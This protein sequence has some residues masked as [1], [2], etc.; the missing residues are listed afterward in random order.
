MGLLSGNSCNIITIL[1]LGVSCGSINA[2]TPVS[3]NGLIA[4]YV[5][6]GTPPYNIL[7]NN[8]LKDSPITNLLPGDYTVTVTDYYGDFSATTTCTVGYDSFYLEKF[9]NCQNISEYAYYLADLTNLFDNGKIYK[10]TTQNGCWTSSG[11]TLFTGQTYINQFA[12]TNFPPYTGCSE[13]LPPPTPQIVYPNQLCLSINSFKVDQQIQF[14]S[15]NTINSYPSWTSTT[16]TIYYNTGNTRWEILNW[17]GDGFPTFNFSTAPPIG[18]WISNGDFGTTTTVFSGV[19]VSPLRINTNKTNPSCDGINDGI[20]V[21]SANGGTSPYT[22]SINGITY[23]TSPTF[24]GLSSGNYTTY[25][26]DFNNNVVTKNLVLS[27]VSSVVSY[28]LNLS[29]TPAAVETNTTTN[30]TK[31]WYWKVDIS[32]SLP[33]NRTVSFNMNFAVNMTGSSYG[34]I[35]STTLNTIV[36]T[37]IN[38]STFGSPINGPLSTNVI[39]LPR[40]CLEYYSSFSSYTTTYSASITGNSFITGY[41]QQFINV[42][43]NGGQCALEGGI[44]DTITITNL[45]INPNTCSNLNTF[46]SP[47]T[48]AINKVGIVVAS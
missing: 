27:P 41:T 8:G 9:E 16:Y 15:G 22:Y 11:T 47:Q 28:V 29:L 38:T 2:S 18:Q 14:Q 39:A 46:V 48:I 44:Q 3:T 12:Q 6:G 10:L 23:Q 19:C 21:I 43:S 4:L 37:P 25:V 17:D 34:S 36:G 33:S 30:K 45:S 20:I 32:P 13:C 35:S 24:V 7:W 31:I 40:P 5:T 42:P 1:P 26:K